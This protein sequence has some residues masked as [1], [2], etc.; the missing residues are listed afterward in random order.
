[1]NIAS[2]P[3]PNPINGALFEKMSAGPSI[4]NCCL[5]YNV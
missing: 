4:A 1:M 2:N 3:C 5:F